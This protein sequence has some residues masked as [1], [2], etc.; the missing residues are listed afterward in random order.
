MAK[1]NRKK[2][3]EGG[4]AVPN[5]DWSPAPVE[6]D[7]APGEISEEE[8]EADQV[9]LDP[10]FLKR[11]F[12]EVHFPA[13]KEMVLRLVDQEQDFA[14]GLDRTVN[15]HNLITHMQVDEFRTRDDLLHAIRERL[16]HHEA[17]A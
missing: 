3:L 9:L 8:R 13:S 14:Y 10:S 15:L 4:R 7:D 6:G 16:E 11:T 1:K 5:A 17:G 2:A 12:A